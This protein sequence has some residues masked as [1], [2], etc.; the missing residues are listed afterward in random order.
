MIRHKNITAPLLCLVLTASATSAA[1]AQDAATLYTEKTCVSCHGPD[2]KTPLLPVYPKLAGQNPDYLFQQLQ[3]IKNNV[4]TNSMSA[5]MAGIMQNVNEEE[6]RI[7]ADWL[8]G[9]D[10]N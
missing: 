6:M 10:W 9:L 7:L 4:R 3:D 8:G 2:A 5:A 1:F